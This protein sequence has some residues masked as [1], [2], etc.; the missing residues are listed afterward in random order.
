MYASLYQISEQQKLK[1]YLIFV[2]GRDGKVEGVVGGPVTIGEWYR[3][4][5]RKKE[6]GVIVSDYLREEHP[7]MKIRPEDVKI[8]PP[9]KAERLLFKLENR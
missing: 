3:K 8:Y 5:I 4:R 6:A 9:L 7:R 1:A 2:V